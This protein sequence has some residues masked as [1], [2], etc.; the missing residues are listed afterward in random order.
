MITQTDQSNGYAK[1]MKYL[2]NADKEGHVVGVGHGWNDA[3]DT[4]EEE[5]RDAQE[6]QKV[7]EQRH[8][9][10][11]DVEPGQLAA[12]QKNGA[13]HEHEQRRLGHQI[14][15]DARR[16][17]VVIAE[18]QEEDDDTDGRGR[19]HQDAGEQAAVGRVTVGVN[20]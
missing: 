8:G 6:E 17:V 16:D 9:L 3:E 20:D 12:R 11:V 13:D 7:V 10:R 1:V 4:V 15:P 14:H 2:Q 18:G 5:A 19:Q